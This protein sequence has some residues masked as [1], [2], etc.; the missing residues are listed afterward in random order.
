MPRQ[1]ATDRRSLTAAHCSLFAVR[2]LLF[3][4]PCSRFPD[5]GLRNSQLMKKKAAVN[6]WIVSMPD[7][8]P[9]EKEA[10]L[11]SMMPNNQKDIPKNQIP[12]L[13]ELKKID[14]SDD[15]RS[16]IALFL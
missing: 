2:C 11:R 5:C 12:F 6:S 4:A 15:E 7:I 8:E 14:A 13:R 10:I 3:A 9:S 1:I 16:L